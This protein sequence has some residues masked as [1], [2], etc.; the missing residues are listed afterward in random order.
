MGTL[1]IGLVTTAVGALFCFRGGLAL[2]VLL[3]L[4]GAL[5]GFWLGAALAAGLTGEPVLSG[6]LGWVAAVLGAIVAGGL[7]Y[8][9][10]VL[11]VVIGFGGVGAA[12]GGALAAAFGATGGAVSLAAAA[13]AVALVV[14]ALATNL[15]FALLVWWSALG[16]A[17]ALTTG[18]ALLLGVVD[19][20]ADAEA[21]E[22]ALGGQWW[23]TAVY[24]ALV[25][26]G[27]VVQFRG[28]RVDARSQWRPVTGTSAPAG[29]DRSR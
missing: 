17:A 12:L 21:I 9:F 1:V 14:V 26:A 29:P 25:V 15:P 27:L 18:L 19:P 6:P 2:R 7:A 5:A 23:W 24:L 22:A 16:G 8:G 4:W 13:G 3:A 20:G 28:A 11:A 10:Y